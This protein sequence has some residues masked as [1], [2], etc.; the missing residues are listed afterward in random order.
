MV[1]FRRPRV[2]LARM[3]V[4]AQ[5][6][7]NF[8]ARRLFHHMPR[9]RGQVGAH[10]PRQ[11]PARPRPPPPLFAARFIHAVR[12]V[13]KMHPGIAEKNTHRRMRNQPTHRRVRHRVATQHRLLSAQLGAECPIEAQQRSR[14]LTLQPQA[15]TVFEAREIELGSPL[16]VAK[17]V[18]RPPIQVRPRRGEMRTRGQS[19]GHVATW[20]AMAGSSMRRFRVEARSYAWRPARFRPQPPPS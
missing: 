14:R 10:D 16:G 1:E 9:I 13:L 2:G 5:R 19:G 17:G 11:R 7:E 6:L 3:S 15:M 18:Q 4:D 8:C 20:R 12:V